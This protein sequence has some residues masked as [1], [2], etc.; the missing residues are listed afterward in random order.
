MANALSIPPIHVDH[1]ADA[2]CAALDSRN[3]VR[4]VVG[5]LRMRE[6]SGWSGEHDSEGGLRS[7][8]M[9]RT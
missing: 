5:V 9:A 7:Q 1:V 8:S 3:G 4:G 2:I 6:L